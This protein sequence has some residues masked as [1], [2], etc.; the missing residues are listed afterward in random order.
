MIDG[1]AELARAQGDD[2]ELLRC[3]DRRIE[4]EAELAPVSVLLEAAS[5]RSERGEDSA[6]AGLLERA[7][8]RAPHDALVAEALSDTLSR[9]GR[10][11]DLVDLLER[12]A[13]LAGRD[14]VAQAAV[15]AELGALQEE[16]L[17]DSDAA[18]LAYQRAFAVDPVAPGVA[19]A[20]DRL[21]RKVEDWPSLRDLLGRAAAA[22][23]E[24]ERPA[25]ACALGDLLADRMAQPAEAARAYQ[26]ALDL[27]SRA[28]AATAG[29]AGSQ[30]SAETQTRCS[31]SPRASRRQHRTGADGRARPRAG[32]GFRGARPVGTRARLGTALGR[33]RP[34]QHRAAGRVR[35]PHAA[36]GSD[37]ELVA[38]LDRQALL[39]TGARAL[40]NRRRLALHHAE[41]GRT[42]DSI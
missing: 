12:R 3:L 26:T 19:T 25:F 27:D 23:P 17:G 10:N 15:L 22:G 5:L 21:Y 28:E 42:A 39:L 41:R 40:P 20:L 35:A 37:E 1:I 34:R 31:R 24:T 33:E 36:L 18:A 2:E 30:S 16:Q 8:Q 13:A 6:A 29:C 14:S 11:D 32:A 4:L 38:C 7:L 9:L